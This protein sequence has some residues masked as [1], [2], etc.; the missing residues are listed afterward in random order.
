MQYSKMEYNKNN[1]KKRVNVLKPQGVN[2][3]VK[4]KTHDQSKDILAM[5]GHTYTYNGSVYGEIIKHLL[6]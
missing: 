4:I 2:D 5:T 6:K 3:F 1:T